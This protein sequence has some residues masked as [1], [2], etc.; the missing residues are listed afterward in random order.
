MDIVLNNGDW[1]WDNFDPIVYENEPYNEDTPAS[2]FLAEYLTGLSY[3]WDN[4]QQTNDERYVELIKFLL[5][6]GMKLQS[7]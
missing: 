4:Y 3:L 2:V 5:P 1:D 7:N 6:A